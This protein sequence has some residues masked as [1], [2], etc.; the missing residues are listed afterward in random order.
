M[1]DRYISA[2]VENANEVILWLDFQERRFKG[3]TR[4]L[5]DGTATYGLHWLRLYVPRGDKT[6]GGYTLRHTDRTQPRFIPGGPGGGGV[7]EAIV[8]IR[9]GT[10]KHPLYANHG[11]GIYAGR[12]LIRSR[13]GKP[14]VFEK[15]GEGLRFAYNTTGQQAQHFLYHTFT[16]MKVY[17][18]ARV[19]KFGPELLG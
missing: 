11:T 17:A 15:R 13:T 9:R 14:M 4:R 16:E 6:D 8:G 7:W 1:T 12:G 3:L 5:I 10:S 19:F 2:E 18:E